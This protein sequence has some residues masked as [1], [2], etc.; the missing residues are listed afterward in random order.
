MSGQEFS[1]YEFKMES[2]VFKLD[3]LPMRAFSNITLTDSIFK[4]YPQSTVIVNDRAGIL[5]D[6]IYFIEGLEFTLQLGNNEDGWLKN[7]YVW[8]RNDVSNIVVS[9]FVSGLVAFTLEYYGIQ[10]DNPKARAWSGNITTAVKDILQKDYEITD[11]Q[12]VTKTSGNRTRYQMNRSNYDFIKSLSDEAYNQS[13]PNSPFYTFFNSKGEFYFMSIGQ[14][15]DQ[16]PVATFKMQDS[17]FEDE[18]LIKSLQITSLG[19]NVSKY[20]YN[21]KIYKLDQNGNTSSENLFIKDYFYKSDPKAKLLIKKTDAN[22]LDYSSCSHLGIIDSNTEAEFYKGVKNNIFTNSNTMYRMVIVIEFDRL[23]CA[24]KVIELDIGSSNPRKPKGTEHSG[25]WL[26]L[27]SNTQMDYDGTPYMQ[28]S[29]G[30]PGIPIDNTH[31]IY[32]DFEG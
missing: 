3:A 26:V 15:F 17:S 7:K 1:K 19:L 11:T 20:L 18:G 31:P 6:N 21:Q 12:Y 10:K 30:R 29:I 28:L 32:N 23:V 24:G 5:V 27:E 9:D 2:D 14:M 8:T 22:P 25:K 4:F 16:K 13:Y